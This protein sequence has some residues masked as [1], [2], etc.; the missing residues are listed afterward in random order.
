MIGKYRMIGKEIQEFVYSSDWLRMVTSVEFL[1]I[2]SLE[3]IRYTHCIEKLNYRTAVFH[4]HT[5][6]HTQNL[7]NMLEIPEPSFQMCWFNFQILLSLLQ[8]PSFLNSF[9]DVCVSL[10]LTIC[11]R[12]LN[13]GGTATH[14]P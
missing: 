8:C 2:L 3:T 11:I 12:K 4:T 10:T 7:R 1:N 9:I 13:S 5:H 6:T 14:V